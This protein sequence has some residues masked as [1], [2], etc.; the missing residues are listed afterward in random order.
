MRAARQVVEHQAAPTEKAKQVIQVER[1]ETPDQHHTQV[2][3][4]VAEEPL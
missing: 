4:E 3:A 2:Q 1:A